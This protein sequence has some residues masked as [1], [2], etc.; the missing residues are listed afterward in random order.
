MPKP[1]I[2]VDTTIPSLYHSR[3]TDPKLVVW[4]TVTRA[5]WKLALNSCELLTSPAVLREVARG[6]SDLVFSRLEM[7]EDLRLL[8]PDEDIEHTAALYV[9]HRI[10]PA[11]LQ[12][13]ALHL[14]M[15]SH[16]ECDFLVTWNYHHLA[17]PNKLDRIRK[18]NMEHGLS[19]PRILTRSN[20]WR[21]TYE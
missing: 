19:V 17:N 2:Y 7:L 4:R 8:L 15:A 20:C 12:G 6:R 14:A 16:H 5:W 13:D 11:D 21:S 9:R 10:M 1:R 18:L 3:R